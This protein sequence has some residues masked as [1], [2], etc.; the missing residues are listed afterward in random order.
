MITRIVHTDDEE[1]DFVYQ[2]DK[3]A[4][5]KWRLVSIGRTLLDEPEFDGRDVLWQT[6]LA[7][8]QGVQ[9]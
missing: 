9:T 4:P 1:G 5:F 6:A 3:R 8:H 7:V 2:R